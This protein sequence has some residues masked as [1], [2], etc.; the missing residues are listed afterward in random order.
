MRLN[1]EPL[2]KIAVIGSGDVLGIALCEHLAERAIPLDLPHCDITSRFH[3]I[4]LFEQL[5]PDAVINAMHMPNIELAEEKANTS[6]NLHVQGASNVAEAARRTGAFLVQLS[7]AEIF[8][9]DA[10]AEPAE[11]HPWKEEETPEPTNVFGRTLLEAE[12]VVSEYERH[13][14]VRTSMLFGTAGDRSGGNLV[15][16]VLRAARRTRKMQ[17]VDDLLTSPTWA[18]DL[19]RAILSLIEQQAGGLVHI[20]NRGEEV[21][22]Y[23]LATETVEKANLKLQIEPITSEEYGF[24][25]PRSRWTVLDSS[26]YEN[27]PGHYP[28][29]HW[30]EALRNHLQQS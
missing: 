2:S 5:Q 16:T 22:F 30:R 23:Q 9:E 28:M 1:R 14:I 25:A 11:R 12:R 19:A 29:P 15:A 4:Q 8:G 21:S 27:M 26:R 17:V 13:L 20:V 10:S 3:L 6:R 18:V 24:R 7:S